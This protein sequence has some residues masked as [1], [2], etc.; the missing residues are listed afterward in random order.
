LLLREKRWIKQETRRKSNGGETTNTGGSHFEAAEKNNEGE[1][2]RGVS[3]K[4]G[5]KGVRKNNPMSGE[6]WQIS[7]SI[8]QNFKLQ[9]NVLEGPSTATRKF[10]GTGLRGV[11][12]RNHKAAEKL[13]L[14]LSARKRRKRGSFGVKSEKPE[15]KVPLQISQKLA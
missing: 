10:T 7:C 11:S 3:F 6:V 15:K 1:K 5:S 13:G 8:V 4:R 14:L 12:K 2:K 9:E